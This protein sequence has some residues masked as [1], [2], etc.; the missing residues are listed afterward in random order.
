MIIKHPA[1]YGGCLSYEVN[2][3]H[4]R[5]CYIDYKQGV[6]K[7]TLTLRPDTPPITGV[8]D[9]KAIF[10][11]EADDGT[12]VNQ[13]EV[14]GDG[15]E[16][17]TAQ[18]LFELNTVLEW[19]I[20]FEVTVDGTPLYSLLVSDRMVRIMPPPADDIA[21]PPVPCEATLELKDERDKLYNLPQTFYNVYDVEEQLN[22]TWTLGYN[23][24]A[25]TCGYRLTKLGLMTD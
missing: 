25:D 20:G 2:K 15:S 22:E 9:I 18:K 17:V 12:L 7:P 5:G 1:D 10:Y 4:Q 8:V 16:T 14:A 24:N 13:L 23:Y 6:F 19:Q 3:Y 21:D 11:T